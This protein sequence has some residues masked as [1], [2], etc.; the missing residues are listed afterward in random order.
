MHIIEYFHYN[1][2]LLSNNEQD[3]FLIAA[4]C[5]EGLP[6]RMGSFMYPLIHAYMWCEKGTIKGAFSNDTILG[7]D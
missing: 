6:R 2:F 3:V 7:M 4:S 5:I 1:R